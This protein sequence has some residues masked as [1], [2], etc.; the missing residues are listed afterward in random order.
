MVCLWWLLYLDMFWEAFR[1]YP[2]DLVS[3]PAQAKVSRWYTDVTRVVD[4]IAPKCPLHYRAQHSLWFK[5]E[6]QAMKLV[7]K[8]LESKWRRALLEFNLA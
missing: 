1:G 6:L 2:V 4:T 7:R 3:N 5:E 8:Q